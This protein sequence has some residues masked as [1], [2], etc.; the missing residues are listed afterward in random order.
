MANRAPIITNERPAWHYEEPVTGRIMTYTM[1]YITSDHIPCM[2]LFAGEDNTPILIPVGI[3]VH[4]IE[5]G[6]EREAQ[7]RKRLSSR[8]KRVRKVAPL[9]KP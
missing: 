5:I 4:G 3:L 1:G 7:A 8:R 6:A 2:A 9:R